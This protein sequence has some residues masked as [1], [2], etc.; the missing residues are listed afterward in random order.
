MDPD[1]EYLFTAAAW[2]MTRAGLVFGL[3]VLLS[4]LTVCFAA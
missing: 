2:L 1:L 4:W 3:A